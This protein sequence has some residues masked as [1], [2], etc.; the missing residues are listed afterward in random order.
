MKMFSGAIPIKFPDAPPS[1]LVGMGIDLLA[2]LFLS[3]LLLLGGIATLRRRSSGP[4]QLRRYAYIRIGLALPLLLMGFWLLGPATEWAAGIARATND[5][6][7]SQKPPLP[8]TEAERA[9]ERPSDPSIWQRGQ[10]VGGCIV[11]LIYPAVVLIV[12]ARPRVRE[13]HARWEA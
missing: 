2:S 12:L 10:V 13:E 1:M 7:S 5:W 11:G 9:S 4:R 6:K 3:A 8:V